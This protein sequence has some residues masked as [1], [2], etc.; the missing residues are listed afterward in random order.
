MDSVDLRRN[1]WIGHGTID[2]SIDICLFGAFDD[3]ACVIE[4]DL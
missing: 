2:A 1:I 3:R 4:I